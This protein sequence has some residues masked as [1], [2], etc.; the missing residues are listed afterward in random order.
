MKSITLS[1]LSATMISAIGG[2]AQA[3]TPPPTVD[4]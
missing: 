3:Q 1:I 2:I 4:G